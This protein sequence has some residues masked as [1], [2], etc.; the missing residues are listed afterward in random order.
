MWGTTSD[1]PG[2]HDARPRPRRRPKLCPH[3]RLGSE[4]SSQAP[5]LAVFTAR[6]GRPTGFSLGLLCSIHSHVEPALERIRESQ[7][8]ARRVSAR[9]VMGTVPR[10]QANMV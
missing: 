3:K 7:I 1:S 5:E 8:G 2:A 4:D 9:N 6:G 10:M